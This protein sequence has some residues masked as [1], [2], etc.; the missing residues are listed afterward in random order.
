MKKEKKEFG[1][2]IAKIAFYWLILMIIGLLLSSVFA[3]HLMLLNEYYE[4]VN[5]EELLRISKIS[6]LDL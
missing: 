6:I 5:Y 1:E 4:D 3:I 2:I